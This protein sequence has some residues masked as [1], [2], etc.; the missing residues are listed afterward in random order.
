[1]HAYIGKEIAIDTSFLTKRNMYINACHNQMTK[2]R[3]ISMSP[4]KKKC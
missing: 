1:M 2:I 3:Y 4:E